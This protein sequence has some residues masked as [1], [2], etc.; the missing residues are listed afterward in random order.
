M[1]NT[2]KVLIVAFLAIC[3]C[4]KDKSDPYYFGTASMTLNGKNWYSS[5]V[6][7]VA[8]KTSPCNPDFLNLDFEVYNNQGFLR[9]ALG[10]RNIFKELKTY[11]LSPTDFSDLS[12]KDSLP[13]CT[14]YTIGAD[15]D[16]VL[17]AYNI[18]PN[19]GSFIR[20]DK[21]NSDTKELEGIFSLDLLIDSRYNPNA[22][23]TLRVRN[24]KFYTKIL[25]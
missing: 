16:V 22:P 5:K 18:Q 12:C 4:K 8:L 20:M 15:G 1:K 7:C 25:Y 17:D 3:S 6:R 13:K 2:P 9:E 24:G 21:F 10:F 23:D 11:Y 14:Y 19:S